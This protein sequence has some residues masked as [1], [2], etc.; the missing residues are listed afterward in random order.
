MAGDLRVHIGK[1]RHRLTIQTKASTQETTLGSWTLASTNTEVRWGSIEPITGRERI[2][3]GQQVPEAT[4][5]IR[6]R[7]N[8]VVSP[9][10]RI[11]AKGSRFFEIMSVVD[12]DER[13]I[14]LE[15]MCKELKAN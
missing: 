15:C 14:V 4:H 10:D 12:L 5:L 13:Q 2:R 11:A 3:A 9:S 6:M 8:T 7:Y 1:M